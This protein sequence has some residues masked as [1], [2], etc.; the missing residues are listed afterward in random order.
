MFAPRNLFAKGLI[1]LVLVSVGLGYSHA[2]EI[3][4]GQVP[5][6]ANQA[7]TSDTFDASLF[8]PLEDLNLLSA[9]RFTTLNHPA[10]P[11]YSVRV[12]KSHFCDGNVSAYTGYIDIEARHLFFY[13]FESR[14]DPDHDDVIFW[15]SGG[16]GGS[17]GLGLFMELG[18]CRVVSENATVYHPHSWNEHA[19]IFFVDQPIGV[20]F[21]Y[22]EYGETVYTSQEGGKDIAAFVAIFFEHFSKFKGRAFH[23]AGESYGGTYVPAFAAALYDQNT[24]IEKLGMT[25]VNLSSIMLGNGCT[26]QLSMW[27]AYY[28]MQCL[29]TTVSPVIDISTCIQM[30]QAVPRCD[31]WVR[32]SCV[33]TFD[34][35]NC[36]AALSFCDD[37]I[38]SPIYKSGKC[39]VHLYHSLCFHILAAGM[40]PYDLSKPWTIGAYLNSTRIREAIGAD[41]AVKEFRWA[42][43]EVGSNFDKS[44]DI[45]FPSQFYIAALLERGVKALIYVGD[46]DLMCN[47][48]GNERMTLDLEWSGQNAFVAAPLREWKVGGEHAGVT[49]SFGGL[50][51]V[52]IAG[53]GH[54]VSHFSIMTL[55]SFLS[56]T[57]MFPKAFS[58]LVAVFGLCGAA[59]ALKRASNLQ[60]GLRVNSQFE[61]YDTGLFAPLEDLKLLSA[62][63]FTTLGHPAFP[64]YNV[65]IKKS[66]D[67]CDGTVNAY[68][69]YIDIEARHIFFYFF[70]SRSDPA[71][72]DVIFWTNGG[73]GCSSSLG[74]FMELG[75]CRVTQPNATTFNPYAWNEN[76][77]IFF[78]DQP[79]GVG[80][81]Y[82]DYG[83]YVS[84]T[85][86]AATDIASF[87]AIFFEHF[88]QFKGR[89][90]HMAGES[91]G[92]KYVPAFAAH[93]YDLNAKLVEVGMTPVNLTSV[94][95]GNGCTNF[96]TMTPSYYDMQC[97]VTT[98]PRCVKWTKESCEDTFDAINCG[99]A[100][101]FCSETISAPFWNTEQETPDVLTTS[102]M[103]RQIAAFLDRPDVRQ[104]I[105]VDPSLT[106]KF[107]SCSNEVGAH[108]H[109]GNDF[110]FPSQLYIAAL[111]ERGVRALLYVGAN[112][113][114]CNWVGNERLSLALEWSGQEEFVSQPLNEW[115]FNGTA[116]GKV[117]SSGPFTFATIYGAGHMVPYDKPE[118]S[119]HLVQR[120]LAN[121]AL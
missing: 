77:N 76:A 49:R 7:A 13:F 18:P 45:I 116:A 51:Y 105:G 112:D 4:G 108:F 102:P 27:T 33:D 70:E 87:V 117:R 48:I 23:M 55:T 79:I 82:A 93:V 37:H 89:P 98:V 118:A 114:I 86:E 22:A 39:R 100:S 26:E 91:Y 19:N 61:P 84:T 58:T 32:K 25:P 92:G 65:R 109:A 110:G 14:H 64:N 15:T 12:K 8:S 38:L 5:L 56:A 75:P 101:S 43:L 21:S 3:P 73:P 17:S 41:P 80:F 42:S 97:T 50:T 78:V 2:T 53:A 1:T 111:L 40:D 83:E 104:T 16:P 68:T 46:T 66:T 31:A 44:L 10:F 47:W 28:E 20:G 69:G 103:I 81:S 63:E 52:T 59:L 121:E 35:I 94:M 88:S 99:A 67:F 71:K 60:P 24:K 30:K 9:S 72:D 95:I 57:D 54:M 107:S 85:E 34:M 106:E 90:F 62:S 96:G 113:W 119:L 29:N 115:T 120:W 36:R 11:K 74:L 6:A